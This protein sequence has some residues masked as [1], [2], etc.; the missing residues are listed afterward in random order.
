MPS[1]SSKRPTI[2]LFIANIYRPWEIPQWH[3]VLDAAREHDANLLCFPGRELCGSF[4]SPYDGQANI[5]YEFAKTTRLDGV[6]LW[7]GGFDSCVTQEQLADFCARYADLPFV[8]VEKALEHIPAVMMNDYDAMRETLHHLMTVHGY[9]RIAF[10]RGRSSHVGFQERYRAYLDAMNEQHL[11]IPP[12]FIS[13]IEMNETALR[14]W[15]E[16]LLEQD[17]QAIAGFSDMGMLSVLEMLRTLG[18]RVPDDVAL[19]GFDDITESHASTP[20]LTTTSQPFYEM[21]R[22]AV[23]MLLNLIAGKAADRRVIVTSRLQIRQSC[24]CMNQ[25]VAQAAST[26]VP[27]EHEPFQQAFLRRRPMIA[28]E[29]ARM[30]RCDAQ[31]LPW[32]TEMIDA[33]GEEIDS[34]GASRF[35]SSLERLLQHE[36]QRERDVEIWHAAISLLRQSTLPLLRDTQRDAAE[37]LWQQ[38]RVMIGQ[39]ARRLQEA[40]RLQSEQRAQILRKIEAALITTFD[41]RKLFDMLAAELPPLGIPSCTLALYDSPTAYAY[42]QPLP[43]RST[44]MFAYSPQGRTALDSAEE[45]IETPQVFQQAI[46]SQDARFTRIIEPLYFQD[47]QIGFIV[48]E[49]GLREGDVYEA[50]RVEIS[51]ALQGALLVRRIQEHAEELERYRHDLEGLVQER[52]AELIRINT[53]LNDEIVERMRTEKARQIGE[54]QYRMLAEHVKNGI[55][56]VQNGK[57]VFV[58][59]AFSE[60]IER[61]AQEMLDANPLSLFMDGMR[62]QA[63]A[64]LETSQPD[65]ARS[66]W[67]VE[68]VTGNGQL[69]WVEI[70]ES[71]IVWNSQFALLLTVRNIHQNKLREIRLEEERAR[72]RQENLTFRSAMSER[73]RFGALVG[74]SP[75]MQRIYELVINAATS[76]V[77]VMLVGESGT[78]K[79]LIA[80]TIHQVS[81]RKD[82]PFVPVNCASIPETLFEREFFGHRRGAFTGADRDAPGLFDRAHRGM[83]FLDEVTELTPAMQAKLLRVLQDGEYTPLG[84]NAA[85]R[86]DVT[87]I[88]ATNKDCRAEIDAKRLRQDFFYRIAVIELFVPPLR[89]RREDL[90]LLIEHILEQYWQKHADNQPR[91]TF[92]ELPPELIQALY[93]YAWPGNVRELQNVLQRYLATQDLSAILSLTGAAPPS[94][95]M[96]VHVETASNVALLE[97]VDAFEKQMIADALTRAHHHIGKTADLLGISRL[98]LY[99]KMKKH[100]LRGES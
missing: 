43:S 61:S 87:I 44:V 91:Q 15:L 37:N 57:F 88:A 5:I 69:I 22:T 85:K 41:I 34:R 35:L 94:R 50:L 77:N 97:A 71:A 76:G 45:P 32:L 29:I 100:Q 26:Q 54:Q 6:I 30:T 99:R 64:F 83:L 12:T 96:P 49:I 53:R 46:L 93:A 55:V 67:Q 62:Q 86:A 27:L 23:E 81:R 8:M 82:L 31:L 90:P 42:P 68:I 63:A 28:Q 2:G 21:G 9:R 40:L 4:F 20:P 59:T 65:D 11:L 13:D 56:I 39:I 36:A 7:T 73:Y 80:H 3:G 66:A 75:A 48:L 24:G 47:E 58:N 79:E 14:H 38:A 89:E 10:M 19:T 1:N 18:K 52:T 74:K 98:M 78:G 16:R 25:I 51:S 92:S 72:L 17:V 60:M 95:V 70:E 33:F 84:G